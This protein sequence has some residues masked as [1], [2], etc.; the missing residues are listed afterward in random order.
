MRLAKRAVFSVIHR[1]PAPVRRAFLQNELSE[2]RARI[3]HRFL[4][5]FGNIVQSGPF[6]GMEIPSEPS[7]GDGDRLQKL[8]GSYESELHQWIS[9]I[10]ARRYDTILNIGCAEGYYAVGLARSAPPMTEVFAYDINPVA[11]RVCAR[12]AEKN[13][14]RDRVKVLGRCSSES[15]RGVLLQG[16]RSFAFVD[17]EGAELELLR[18]DRVPM[19][20]DTDILV[21]C[22]DFVDPSIT[23]TL[24]R[25]L[26][27]THSIER[28]DEGPRDP[29]QFPFLKGLSGI[30][31]S[32]A[33]CEFR[34]EMMHWL[35]CTVKR[36]RK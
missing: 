8:L 15:L 29:N 14:V 22:H 17:C 27:P 18:P 1:I 24:Y 35:L 34:P 31:R 5:E 33:V 6:K 23:G 36:I 25:R 11:R 9:R 10:L 19:L 28:V 20:R 4:Q 26:S 7:W 3:T 2:C 16:G 30:E 12:A 13:G 21:E 32:L